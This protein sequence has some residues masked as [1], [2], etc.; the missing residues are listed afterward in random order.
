M[1]NFELRD[2]LF[3]IYSFPSRVSEFDK[4]Q[5]FCRKIVFWLTLEDPSKTVH[6]QELVMIL[7]VVIDNIVDFINF[8]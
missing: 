8:D 3:R 1:N 6:I 4:M 7:K 5:P 2:Q